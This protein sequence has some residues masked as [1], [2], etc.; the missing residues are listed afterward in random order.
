MREF[1]HL[2]LHI[3]PVPLYD[4]SDKMYFKEKYTGTSTAVPWLGLCASTA[5]GYRS[6]PWWG[7]KIPHVTLQKSKKEYAERD[8]N[9]FKRK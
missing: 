9:Y 3:P 2:L 7:T 5:G 6:H 8:D 1:S 4:S